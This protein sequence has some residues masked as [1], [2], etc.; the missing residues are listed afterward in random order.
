MSAVSVS[1]KIPTLKST[2][3]ADLWLVEE[4]GWTRLGIAGS[5]G[6]AYSP[7]GLPL[8]EP[9]QTKVP[10]YV[11]YAPDNRL[12]PQ[13]ATD[14]DGKLVACTQTC[15]TYPVEPMFLDAAV[16]WQIE[17][18][19]AEARTKAR[20]ERDALEEAEAGTVEALSE[21]KSRFHQARTAK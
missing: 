2:E 5:P 14:R 13:L 7:P 8:H 19:L 11:R 16:R 15:T 10:V 21:A 20:R 1:D 12:L 9:V 17:K 3:E 4:K 6:C 18:N